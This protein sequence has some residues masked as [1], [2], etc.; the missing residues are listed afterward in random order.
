MR[1]PCLNTRNT[2]YAQNSRAFHETLTS[3]VQKCQGHQDE[4]RWGAI[5]TG[6]TEERCQG[7]V[8]PWSQKGGCG[9]MGIGRVEGS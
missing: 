2:R 5:Q 9:N 1:N 7:H 8:W 4:G 6:G 3:A